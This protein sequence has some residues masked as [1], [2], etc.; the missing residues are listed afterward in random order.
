MGCALALS[1]W[2]TGCGALGSGCSGVE[3]NTQPGMFGQ[4]EI[5]LRNTSDEPKLVTLAIVDEEG[6]EIST[7]T[8][9]VD[10]KD[11]AETAVGNMRDGVS[12]EMAS[13]E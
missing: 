11:I 5:I 1:A 12:I 3:M 9:R 8:M 4:T 10:S 6:E 13:C 2:L 7:Q